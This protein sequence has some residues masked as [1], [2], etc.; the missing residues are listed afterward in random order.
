M[1]L[2]RRK[3]KPTDDPTSIGNLL[4]AAGLVS[5][6]HISAAVNFQK[7]HADVLMGE[8]LV[9]MGALTRDQLELAILQQKALRTTKPRDARKLAELAAQ[10]TRDAAAA[11]GDVTDKILAIPRRT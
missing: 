3:R 9:R 11:L 4:C 10:R 8:A 6:M 2:L 7:E 5:S 1:S